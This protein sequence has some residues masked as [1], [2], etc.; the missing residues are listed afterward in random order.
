MLPEP[1]G[2]GRAFSRPRLQF[3]TVIR[4]D[5]EPMMGYDGDGL[6]GPTLSRQMTFLFSHSLKP[7]FLILSLPSAQTRRALQMQ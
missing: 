7:F 2:R 1:A 5:Q 3:F 6:L 4:T